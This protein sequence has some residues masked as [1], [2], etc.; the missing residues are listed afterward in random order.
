MINFDSVIYNNYDNATS[1]PLGVRRT[2]KDNRKD[3][4]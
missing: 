4:S 1:H 3:R 2:N